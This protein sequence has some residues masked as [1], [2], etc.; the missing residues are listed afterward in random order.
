MSCHKK[1]LEKY[2]SVAAAFTIFAPTLVAECKFSW[3]LAI[4][5]W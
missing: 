3:G 5:G 4:V 1:P 2:G